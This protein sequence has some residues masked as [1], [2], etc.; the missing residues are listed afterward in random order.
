MY[1]IMVQFK[2][3]NGINNSKNRGTQYE[4]KDILIKN[5][6]HCIRNF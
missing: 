4:I 3:A 5:E 2:N 6:Y 1:I